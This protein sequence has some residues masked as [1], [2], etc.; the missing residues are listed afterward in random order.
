[1]QKR[2]LYLC[3]LTFIGLSKCAEAQISGICGKN[4]NLTWELTSD[5]TLTIRGY[6]EMEDSSPP[7]FSYKDSIKTIIIYDSVTSIGNN[8]FENCS[9]LT[10]VT[11]G[12]SV[13][14]IGVQAFYNCSNIDS[15]N[16][17]NFVTSID[18]LAF[19]NCSSLTYVHIPYSVTSISGA[20]EGCNNLTEI[21]VDAT[22]QVFYAKN[23][24]L[25][26]DNKTI[27]VCYPSVKGEYTVPTNVQKID[28]GCFANCK[29]LTSI[30]IPNSQ[31]IEASVFWGCE[32]LETVDI[33]SSVTNIGWS[34][35]Y[36]CSSLTDVHVHWETP[37][38]IEVSVFNGVTVQ[39][40]YLHVPAGTESLYKVAP[41]WK[42]FKI[43]TKATISGTV[44]LPDSITPLSAGKVFL[45]KEQTGKRYPCIDSFEIVNNGKYLFPEVENGKY[46]IRAKANILECTFPTYYGNTEFWDSAQIITITND[47]IINSKDIIML[48][49]PPAMSGNALIGGQVV[50][51]DGQQEGIMGYDDIQSKARKG[52][53]PAEDVDVYLDKSEDKNKWH[54][55]ASARTDAGGNFTFGNVDS[56][57]FYRVRLDF[58]GIRIDSIIE[59]K[60]QGNETIDSIKLVIPASDNSIRSLEEKKIKIYPNPT[61][62][63]L[64]IENYELRDGEI[65]IYDIVGR[66][67]P[68]NPPERGKQ[69]RDYSPPSEGLGEAVIDISHL[70]NGLY[71]LKIGSKTFK[72]IKN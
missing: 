27:L 53:R 19:A 8:A 7:W 42:D 24:I 37:L 71:L 9:N 72:I 41:V 51:D 32:N 58:A 46:I 68:L 64:R 61:N 39:N 43:V 16:I 29:G 59:D 33:G 54:T 31:T 3:M 13:T 10:S 28:N 66:K 30:I 12:D 26:K 52:Q 50:E 70:A 14:R 6:D 22:N 69:S 40:V 45:Y 47:T 5:S 1:M 23:G 56:N 49:C 38:W 21:D 67:A 44:I 35:F 36:G 4:G 15:V 60:V 48:S 62:S 11:I 25:F 65:A 17:P 2:V 18:F 20:F 63:Q 57:S 55:V 34:V